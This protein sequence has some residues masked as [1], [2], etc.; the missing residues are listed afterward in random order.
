MQKK[1]LILVV[2]VFALILGFV[3]IFVFRERILKLT[4]K[5]P[6]KKII[7][8][9]E[10]KEEIQRIVAIKESKVITRWT[11]YAD[12]E[13]SQISGRSLT[14]TA[15]GD[16]LEIPIGEEI[17]ITIPALSIEGEMIQ[18]RK[19]I[20]FKDIKIGDRV[21]ISLELI[22]D[23]LKV[24]NAAVLSGEIKPLQKPKKI[25]RLTAIAEG[26]VSQIS[27]RSLT[28]T[29]NGDSLKIPIREKANLT[30]FSPGLPT[31][32]I[33]FK[34]IKV[35]DMVHIFGDLIDNELKGIN[36]MVFL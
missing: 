24:L 32:A 17:E 13:V 21:D 33:D 3:G 29:T 7:T 18:K 8:F 31:K 22:E 15:N 28:L 16:A 30:L 6:P 2:I 9:E 34:D 19:K 25:L 20:D 35:G 4:S 27:D 23:E 26:K 5:E 36:V 12:G 14:L 1:S 11:A 10:V